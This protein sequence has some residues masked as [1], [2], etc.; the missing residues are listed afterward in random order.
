MVMS[1]KV[2]VILEEWLVRDLQ[3]RLTQKRR[4]L[5][6]MVKEHQLVQTQHSLRANNSNNF[7]RMWGMG[8][9]KLPVQLIKTKLLQSTKDE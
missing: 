9:G 6:L 7:N 8:R 5:R 1:A 3:G 2:I 4:G